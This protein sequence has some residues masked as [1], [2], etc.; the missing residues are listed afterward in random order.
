M[1]D[2]LFPILNIVDGWLI[3]FEAPALLRICLWSGVCGAMAMGV[4]VVFSNQEQIGQF[5]LQIKDL[6]RRMLD[7]E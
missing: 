5:K 1:I 7:P 4:Y 2:S 6:R 3:T